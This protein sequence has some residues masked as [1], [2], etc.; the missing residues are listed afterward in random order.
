VDYLDMYFCHR[1]DV[2]T[3]IEETVLAMNDLI[4]QGKILYWGSSEWSAEQVREAHQV[5][6]D[7]RVIGPTME[8]PEYNLFKR[9]RVELEYAR[10]YETVGLGT[11]IWSPL[12]SGILTGKYENGIP[13]GT[14]ITLKGYEWL[15]E[16]FLS[17]EGQAKI[18]KAKELRLLAESHGLK[19]SQMSLLWCL[20][21]PNVSTVIL[22]AST[23]DQLRENLSALDHK[24]KMTDD[25][26][27]KIENIVKNKPVPAPLY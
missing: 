1:P 5:A 19:L 2:D 3:P 15:R 16:R 17:P 4:R 7:F 25:L 27:Q 9:E 26:M 14:R 23:L 12:A 10:L 20:K 18:A 21:N 24:E 13:E 22:G 8:Q 6:R 11:T